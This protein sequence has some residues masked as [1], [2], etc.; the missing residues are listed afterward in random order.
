TITG[1]FSGTVRFSRSTAKAIVNLGLPV[2]AP[3]RL[4]ITLTV[5]SASGVSPVTG[6]LTIEGLASFSF[7]AQITSRD[8]SISF[9]GP[10]S[11][12]ITG[13]LNGSGSNVNGTFVTT[14]NGQQVS[15]TVRVNKLNIATNGSGNG[16]GTVSGTGTI[17]TGSTIVNTT[18]G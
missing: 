2:A 13:R 6:T 3:R 14:V 4:A 1:S 5:E 11:G 9:S 7:S 8:A 12:T 10:L 16:T 18:A 15:G 17:A